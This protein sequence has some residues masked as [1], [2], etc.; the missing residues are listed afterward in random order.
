MNCLECQRA[1]LADPRHLVPEALAHLEK[2]AG[3]RG[4]ADEL[5]KNEAGITTAF[6]VP[7]PYGLAERIILRR[8]SSARFWRW[9]WW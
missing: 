6:S 4:F 5:R 9:L 8:N 3:C 7:V 2:C 1:A